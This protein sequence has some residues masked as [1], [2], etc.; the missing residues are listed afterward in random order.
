MK[1]KIEKCIFFCRKSKKVKVNRISD[2]KYW[3]SSDDQVCKWSLGK[4]ENWSN[5]NR[6]LIKDT[7][8]A[9]SS[10]GGRF[11]RHWELQWDLSTQ[12]SELSQFYWKYFAWHQ[13]SVS[14]QQSV[15][16]PVKVLLCR[17]SGSAHCGAAVSLTRAS[18]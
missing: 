8:L 4:S 18:S 1:K 15:S 6:K 10:Q 14:S 9:D 11:T 5:I 17:R 7:I 2:K 3:I 16:A 13:G 12:L